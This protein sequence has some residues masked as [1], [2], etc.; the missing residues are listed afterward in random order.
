MIDF[1]YNKIVIP[2]LIFYFRK[3]KKNNSKFLEREKE[4]QS[5]WNSF[6]D[7]PVYKKIIWIHSASMGEFEQIK[8]V[9][10]ELKKNRDYLYIVASFFSPSGYN[11]QK[12]YPYIDKI[13]YM[14]I[15]TKENAERFVSSIHPDIAI[16]VRYEI[17]RNH[18]LELRKLNIPTILVNATMPSNKFYRTCSLTRAF[19]RNNLNLFDLILT[20]GSRHTE[21]FEN[22]GV[23][24]EIRTLTDTRFDRIIQKVEEARIYEVLDK[25]ILD[26]DELV[27]VAGSI[28]EEDE[29]VLLPAIKSVREEIDAQIKLIYVPHEPTE[30][31]IED[32]SSK[33]PSHALSSRIRQCLLEK[34]CK[35]V[36]EK[37]KGK[38]IIVDEIGY[39]LGLY[40]YGHIAY[41]GGAFGKGVHSVIEPAGFG[42]PIITGPNL[43][44]STDAQ[45]LKKSKALKVVKNAKELADWLKFLVLNNE[46][47]REL[48]RIAKEYV[49]QSAGSSKIVTDKI[50]NILYNKEKE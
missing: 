37:L 35:W 11:N 5:Q 15:D 6:S 42:L 1:I 12:D 13:C 7:I 39:L 34:G 3:I 28:W 31:H 24:S 23:K 41:V 32:L 27:I 43:S 21:F 8:P 49:Y 33:I 2:F 36:H 17:W 44:K 14:P 19:L 4:I 16:F 26:P 9:I 18:L 29:E 20:T 48:G 47:R 45:Y 30:E 10:E 22:L 50:I 25:R 38:D 40:Y 46:F